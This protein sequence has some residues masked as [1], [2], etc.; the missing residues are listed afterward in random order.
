M[1]VPDVSVVMSVHNG[2]EWLTGTLDSV[3]NQTGCDFEFIV[4]DDGSTDATA[5]ILDEYATRHA[6]LNVIHQENTG[7]TRALVRGCAAARG[8]FI[9]R[10]DAGDISLPGRLVKQLTTLGNDPELVFVSCET[11]YIA[12]GDEFL[13]DQKGTGVARNPVDIIDINKPHGV[14]DG[15]SSHGSVMFRRGKYDEVGGYRPQF[16]YGQDWDLWYRLAMVGKFQMLH[17]ILYQARIGITDISSCNREFQEKIARLSLEA[18]KKRLA[19]QSENEILLRASKIRPKEKKRFYGIRYSKGGYFLG[20]CL[21]KN[22]D[23]ENAK[24]YFINS[25]RN[26]PFNIKS[27]CRMLQIAMAN[28]RK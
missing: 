11:R 1:M 19:N 14:M 10:Q 26:N 9:A 15:P 24:K 6:S 2:G 18:L 13:Y 21:R 17:E 12:S 22:G 28:T 8:E 25:L 20:E 27:W 23:I 7:L 16:Y 3:L 4:I 5:V